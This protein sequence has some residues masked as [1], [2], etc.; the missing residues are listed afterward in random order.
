M[1]GGGGGAVGRVSHSSESLWICGVRVKLQL[2]IGDTLEQGD[3]TRGGGGVQ[4][5]INRKTVL[6]PKKR[7]TNLCIA[8]TE[9]LG[10]HKK[11]QQQWHGSSN[12][13]NRSGG[14]VWWQ[15][16]HGQLETNG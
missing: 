8:Y 13:S 12:N 3:R 1:S 5:L 4:C 7:E 14:G 6:W 15:E 2:T 11:Q 10:G 9:V 16:C